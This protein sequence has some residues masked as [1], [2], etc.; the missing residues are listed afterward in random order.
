LAFWAVAMDPLTS[1][2]LTLE[3]TRRM[4]QEML[5]AQSEWLPQFEG[6]KLRSVDHIDVPSGTVPVPVP[7]D[8]ALAINARFGKLG[9]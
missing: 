6:K 8:P 7:V 1:A 3:E 4:V 2:V 5:V 9:E